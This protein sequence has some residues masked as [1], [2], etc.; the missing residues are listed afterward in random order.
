M[1]TSVAG[2]TVNLQ[3][4]DAK[5]DQ[6]RTGILGYDNLLDEFTGAWCDNSNT[7][8][9]TYKG[10]FD[11]KQNKLIFKIEQ[12][13]LQTATRR[14]ATATYTFN[15]D[16]TIDYTVTTTDSKGVKFSPNEFQYRKQK[17]L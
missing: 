12:T 13:D 5:R 15:S 6:V 10:S 1:A 2:A 14:S 9:A 3:H 7:G 17:G 4:T 16:S 11:Q 8:L